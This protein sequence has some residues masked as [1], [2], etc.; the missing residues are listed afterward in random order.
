MTCYTVSCYIMYATLFVALSCMLIA[1]LFVITSHILL[2]VLL[3]DDG[4]FIITGSMREIDVIDVSRQEDYKMLMREWTE[5]YNS[6]N[7]DKIFN[8]ISLEFSKTKYVSIDSLYS[9]THPLLLKVS[10]LASEFIA[11][12]GQ[13]HIISCTL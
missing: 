8:V 2:A 10:P 9:V 4:L 7:R 6:P 13:I 11:I 5:Y 1:L 12:Y 3:A